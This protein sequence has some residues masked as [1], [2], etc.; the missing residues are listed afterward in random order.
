MLKIINEDLNAYTKNGGI[1]KKIKWTLLNHT[2]HMGILFRIASALLHIPIIGGL[3]AKALEYTIRILYASDISCKAKIKGGLVFLHGHDI[4]IGADVRMGKNCTVFNGVTL[5]NKNLEY[6][7][8]GNQPT[9]G[10]NV[11][12]STG[13]KVLGPLTIGDNVVV[14]ANSVVLK[15]IPSNCTVVGIPARIIK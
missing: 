12:L 4:V 14:G 3:L 10:D 1:L 11:I 2:I 5:G 15:D 7:S 13:V 9:V 8:F 6:S